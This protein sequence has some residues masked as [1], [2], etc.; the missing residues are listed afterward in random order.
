MSSNLFNNLTL[1]ITQ[2]T[3]NNKINKL[4]DS[5][6]KTLCSHENERIA[7]IGNNIDASLKKH[8]AK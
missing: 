4:S 2:I 8:T 6:K 1:E 7:A 3:I 5:H